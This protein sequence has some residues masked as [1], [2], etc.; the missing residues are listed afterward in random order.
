MS[1]LG[2]VWWPVEGVELVL[3]ALGVVGAVLGPVQLQRLLPHRA[4]L[5]VVAEGGV[6]VSERIEG[7]RFFVGVA[8]VAA[9]GE[10]VLVVVQRLGVVTGVV[11]EVARLSRVSASPSRLWRRRC[12]V[13]AA[14]QWARPWA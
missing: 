11:G 1:T 7:V 12:R 6:E 5:M 13:S 10:G 2:G 3:D 9:L 14:S 4:G 8:E